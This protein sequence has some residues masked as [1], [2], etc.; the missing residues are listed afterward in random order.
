MY[1]LL[2]QIS[3][4]AGFLRQI[5]KWGKKIHWEH[6]SLLFNSLTSNKL[7]ACRKQE[8]YVVNII[9]FDFRAMR[10]MQLKCIEKIGVWTK[11]RARCPLI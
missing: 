3:V 10:E 6:A 8:E 2:P 9:G 11:F 4:H 5:M 1:S 7:S